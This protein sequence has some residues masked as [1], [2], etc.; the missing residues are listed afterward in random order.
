M[1]TWLSSRTSPTLGLTPQPRRPDYQPPQTLACHVAPTRS[2]EDGR[3][4]TAT[5]PPL[6]VETGGPGALPKPPSYRWRTV[7]GHC[8]EVSEALGDEEYRWALDGEMWSLPTFWEILTPCHYKPV[9][10]KNDTTLYLLLFFNKSCNAGPFSLS[11]DR[12]RQI[13][14][15]VTCW[16]TT[17]SVGCRR[18]TLFPLHCTTWGRKSFHENEIK[19]TQCGSHTFKF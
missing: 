5:S 16:N 1:W 7:K 15:Y 13:R 9:P 17:G 3:H 18:W 11:V 2:P 19:R 14:S 4:V 12:K 8:V 6:N 10:E